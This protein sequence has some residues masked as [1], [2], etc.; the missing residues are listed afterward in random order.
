MKKLAGSLNR[1]WLALIGLV[2]IAAAALW[3]LTA[4]G[5]LHQ[6]GLA[7]QP[8]DKPFEGAESALQQEW[9]PAALIAVGVVLALLAVLWLIR[10]VPRAE[11]AD[12]LQFQKDARQG[13]T[14]ADAKVITDAIAA[15]TEELTDVVNAKAVLRGHRSQAE[16]VLDVV[17][18]ERGDVQQVGREIADEVLPAAARVLGR[19]L[20]NVGLIYEVTRQSRSKRQIRIQ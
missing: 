2:L 13:V 6:A 3:I 1:T 7:W 17:I 18:N 5:V 8:E 19:P 10:Q 16:L 4:T 12:T 9:L 11:R 14:V 20:Q 15:H